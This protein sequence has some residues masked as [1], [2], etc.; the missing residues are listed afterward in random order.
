MSFLFYFPKS[1]I[2]L[3]G[4]MAMRISKIQSYE[5]IWLKF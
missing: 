2:R 1:A 3:T 5:P 4:N